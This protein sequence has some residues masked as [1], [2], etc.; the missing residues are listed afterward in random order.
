LKILL[1]VRSVVATLGMVLATAWT[2]SWTLVA[3][4]FFRNPSWVDGLIYAWGR[5]LAWLFQLNIHFGGE[6]NLPQEGCLFVFNHTSHFDIVVFCAAIRK[7]ARFGAKIELFRIPIFGP[8]MR[9]AG[10]LPIHRGEKEKVFQLYAESAS[11]V[12]EGMS[13]VLAGEGTR[14]AQPGVGERFKAG[15]FV[16]A[17]NGQF[18][19]VP[20]VIRGAGEAMPKGR[21]LACMQS[22]RHDVDIQVLP[23]VSTKGL[24]LDDRDL[25]QKKVREQMAA[26][27]GELAQ[28]HSL[29]A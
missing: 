3:A 29:R 1:A 9:A 7:R 19:I 4:L 8:A 5:R 24:S 23:P 28:A 6:K 10:V 20:V 2:A 21:F 26:V 12:R 14:Q 27:Y 18:P 17:I 15:P 13:Y 25:L 11:K 16:F 22:W